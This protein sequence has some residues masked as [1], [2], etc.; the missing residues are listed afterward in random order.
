MSVPT[1]NFHHGV[2]LKFLNCA[3]CKEQS[4]TSEHDQFSASQE[5]PRTLWKTKIH[6]R[7]N[8]SQT[9]VTILNIVA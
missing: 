1:N 6:Y 5:I 8:K 4:H 3:Y 2:W 7:F 9:H